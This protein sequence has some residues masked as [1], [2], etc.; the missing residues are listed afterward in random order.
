MIGTRIK[1]AISSA[2]ERISKINKAKGSAEKLESYRGVE[3]PEQ[4]KTEIAQ[5]PQIEPN[6]AETAMSAPQECDPASPNGSDDLG[7]SAPPAEIKVSHETATECLTC[8]NLIHCDIRSNSPAK[9]IRKAQNGASY[10]LATELSS[11]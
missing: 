4:L 3:R 8:E 1:E 6:I 9:S 2:K 11:K 5:E 10:R 7:N